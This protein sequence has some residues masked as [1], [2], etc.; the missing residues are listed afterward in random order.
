MCAQDLAAGSSLLPLTAGTSID[1]ACIIAPASV[2]WARGDLSRI[3]GPPGK[4]LAT[5]IEAITMVPCHDTTGGE[6]GSRFRFRFRFE[7]EDVRLVRDG[8]DEGVG[9]VARVGR[10]D[11]EC[12]IPIPP[13]AVSFGGAKDGLSVDGEWRM[14]E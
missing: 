5:G 4:F 10:P 3:S 11:I 12:C 7:C 13:L 9:T 6:S 1:D 14:G 2:G 8:W